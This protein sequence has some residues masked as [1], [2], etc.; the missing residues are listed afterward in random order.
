MSAVLV[1]SL[2][3]D[4]KIPGPFA[5]LSDVP[6]AA[7]VA[8]MTVAVGEALMVIG[9][10]RPF[11]GKFAAVPDV[12]SVACPTIPWSGASIARRWEQSGD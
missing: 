11:H 10:P 7:G 2:A 9:R 3:V 6:Y 12:P 8:H 4:D 5:A 1:G